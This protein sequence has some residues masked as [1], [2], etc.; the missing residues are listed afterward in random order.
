MSVV[1]VPFRVVPSVLSRLSQATALQK[2]LSQTK[3]SEDA[4]K[5]QV[6]K[7]TS[8][9]KALTAEVDEKDRAAQHTQDKLNAFMGIMIAQRM[10]QGGGGGGSYKVTTSHENTATHSRSV[11]IPRRRAARA[12]RRRSWL[13]LRM[14]ASS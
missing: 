5:K 13:R 10:F 3:E 14:D 11:L 8:D 6:E 1:D 2:E 9:N 7:A 12:W 4:L